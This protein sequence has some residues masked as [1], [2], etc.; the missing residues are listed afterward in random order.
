MGLR[1]SLNQLRRD[2]SAELSAE[3]IGAVADPEFS[4]IPTY[5]RIRVE[6]V[7]IAFY[8]AV[9][10]GDPSFEFMPPGLQVHIAG[11]ADGGVRIISCWE[12]LQHGR[13][14][15]RERLAGN[16][17]NAVVSGN[18]R[19]DFLR[20]EFPLISLRLG[21]R[22]PEFERHHF[23]SIPPATTFV[24]NVLV[25]ERSITQEVLADRWEMVQNAAALDDRLAGVLALQLSATADDGLEITEVWTDVNEGHDFHATVLPR[26]LA[27]VFG[28]Q[29]V[30]ALR[31]STFP[32]SYCMVND[33]VLR[34][35][36]LLEL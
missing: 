33:V 9:R 12:E 14:F 23:H 2:K 26:A 29:S 6:G 30:P 1:D 8:L 24:T 31:L 22:A 27:E 3:D 28:A 17:Q 18:E 32:A 19:G 36:G 13:E 7:T 16:V 5:T 35:H 34:D 20:E 10:T 4:T 21:N 25:G 15:F 11:E